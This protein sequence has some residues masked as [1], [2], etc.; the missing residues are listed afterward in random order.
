QGAMTF[1]AHLRKSGD[2]EITPAAIL[3]DHFA[4]VGGGP[5]ERLKRRLLTERGSAEHCVLMDLHHGLDELSRAAGVAKSEA[6][7][8]PGLGE[9]VQEDGAVAQSGKA[10]DAGVLLVVGQLGVNLV[11]DDEQ[12]ALHG[13]GG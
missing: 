10:Y 7:H 13:E 9:T 1:Q 2:E 6:S 8:C 12:I 4:N 11:R 5:G 3:R